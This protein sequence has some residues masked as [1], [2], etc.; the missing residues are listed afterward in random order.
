ME[1]RVLPKQF[2]KIVLEEL[3]NKIE[4]LG[5]H[6]VAELYEICFCW[7][8]YELNIKNYV[9][10]SCKCLKDK[11]AYLISEST[12]RNYFEN[13]VP[14]TWEVQNFHSCFWAAKVQYL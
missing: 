1:Q 2:Q 6:R 5:F 12:I 11:E 13:L 9:T 8:E 3:H 4:H 14:F 7:S 10:K